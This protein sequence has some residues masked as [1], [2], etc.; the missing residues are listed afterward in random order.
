[1][2][3]WIFVLLVLVSCANNP[4]MEVLVDDLQVPWSLAFFN[5]GSFLFTER[6][7]G[8]IYHYE[9]TTKQIAKISSTPIGEG[10]LLGVAI[11]PNF[12]QNHFVYIYYTYS[13]GESILNRVSRFVYKDML[14]EETIL[15]DGIPGATYHDGG[16]IEFGPDNKLYITTGDAGQ[17]MLAQ[18]LSSVAGK[19]LRI[20]PDGTIPED[21]PFPTS[22]VYS[23]GHRNIQGLAWYEGTLFASEHG[24]RQND[25]INVIRPGINYGWPLVQCAQHTGYEEPIRCFADW[26]LA[27]GGVTFDTAGNLYVAGLRGTQIRKFTMKDGSIVNEE[28]FL[29]NLGRMR[30][31]KYQDG[32]L[33]MTTSNRDGRGIPRIGDDKIIRVPV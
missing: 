3:R 31:V 19:I 2:K 11:D 1:M 16:R 13:T 24:Q 14:G 30:E 10:G 6:V 21:N 15:V 27:P 8:N 4:Q 9:Q 29:D 25:E 22:P 32:Y 5:D 26:T 7:T 17:E 23:Y 18:D 33:Y 12:D 20:N 28:I